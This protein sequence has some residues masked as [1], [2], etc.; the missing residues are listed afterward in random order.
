M[1]EN[2]PRSTMREFSF[3]LLSNMDRW[4]S[5]RANSFKRHG[6]EFNIFNKSEQIMRLFYILKL[7]FVESH[8]Y[9]GNFLKPAMYFFFLVLFHYT[10]NIILK[11]LLKKTK[12]VGHSVLFSFSFFNF[13]KYTFFSLKELNFNWILM[14]K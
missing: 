11:W 9:S 6:C 3:F 10:F 13:Y 12:Q 8:K 14:S 1:D 7:N 5:D 4:F 2:I